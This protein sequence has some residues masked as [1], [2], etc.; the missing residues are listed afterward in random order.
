MFLIREAKLDDSDMLFKLAR[1]SH[2]VNLPPNK[3]IIE[4]K[5]VHARQCFRHLAATQRKKHRRT[6]EAFEGPIFMFSAEDPDS[7]HCLGTSMIISRMGSSDHPNVAF[8]LEKREFFSDDLHIG[9]STQVLVLN[10]DTTGPTEI[11]GLILT[12]GYRRHAARIGKQLSLI[13]FH[14]IG[15]HRS[16]FGPKLLAEMMAPIEADGSSPFWEYVG[17]RFINL[18]YEE[19]YRASQKTRDFMLNLLPRDPIYV[20]LLPPEARRVI[21]AVGPDTIAARR[22]IEQMGFRYNGNVDPFDGGPHLDVRTDSVEMVQRTRF[23]QFVG[24]C[25]PSKAK[26]EGF[27]SVLTDGGLFRAV[28]TPYAEKSAGGDV[29]LPKPAIE[30]LR[31]DRGETLG[32]TPASLESPPRPEDLEDTVA[33]AARRGGGVTKKTRSRKKT[34]KARSA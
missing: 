12:P 16:L 3:D 6:T 18:T 22:L 29:L 14:F 8:R 32:V 24:S 27:V 4:Q 19:A 30:A 28:H 25:A 26:L 10:L 15:L 1:T 7:G 23:A 34:T 5:I 13:R 33:I 31:L 2:F 21:G 20:S 17:R 11:G 9:T